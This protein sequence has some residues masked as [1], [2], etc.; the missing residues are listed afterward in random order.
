ML[1]ILKARLKDL[2]GEIKALTD[3][4]DMSADDFGTLKTKNTEVETLEGQIAEL[5]KSE[6]ARARAALPANTPVDE[7]VRAAAQVKKELTTVEKIGVMVFSMAKTYKA[8]GVRG[9]EATFKAMDEAGYG[10]VAKDFAGAQARALNSGSASAGGVLLPE[11]MA[12][13]VIDILRPATTFLRGNPRRISLA[14][15]AYK[16][17]AAASGAASNWRGEGQAIQTSQPSFKDIS[18]SAKFLDSMVPLTNQLIR[19]S[20]S[21]VR[22]WVERD[23]AA[24]MGT[25]LDMAAYFG[26][27][28]VNMPLGITKITGVTRL[29]ALGGTAPTIA[30]IETGAAAIELS[31]EG[32][33]LLM[34]GAAWVMAPRTKTYLANLRGAGTDQK[35]FPEISMAVPT[36]RGRPVFLTTQV[37]IVGGGTTDESEILL[38]N[39]DDILFGEG[40]GISFAVSTEA[41]YVKN[42]VVVSAFQNDLTLIKASLEADV[43][44]RYLEAVAV[45]TGVRWGA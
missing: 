12:S 38:V 13:E 35:I 27:G 36:W 43:D 28:G 23:M 3:K 18:L 4:T 17:P 45:L 1:A 25:A 32:R 21:D 10:I 24:S 20:L 37:S 40:A 5:T 31:M 6:E 11:D 42:G 15:G 8:T 26:D 34:A 41:T 2:V 14:H 19:W 44:M 29:A 16:L 22:S 7:T 30:Q 39:F 33:N 9:A